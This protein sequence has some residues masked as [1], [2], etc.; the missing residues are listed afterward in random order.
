MPEVPPG[1]GGF[2]HRTIT[3]PTARTGQ[4][5][6]R[7]APA[8]TEP[9]IATRGRLV[10]RDWRVIPAAAPAPPCA[11]RSCPVGD[12]R[13]S[14]AASRA[15]CGRTAPSARMS[16]FTRSKPIISIS[17]AYGMAAKIGRTIR[18]M[19]ERT[20]RYLSVWNVHFLVAEGM[21]FELTIRLY[22]V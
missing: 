1:Q 15:R 19:G 6:S 13:S 21:R 17:S 8:R 5:C 22:T 12:P 20:F 14:A 11:G 16:S 9:N 18:D 3:H 4:P 2:R 10:T 7:S